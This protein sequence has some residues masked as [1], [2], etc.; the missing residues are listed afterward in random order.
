MKRSSIWRSTPCVLGSLLG[1]VL[2]KLNDFI[3]RQSWDRDDLYGDGIA[4]FVAR[5]DAN[6]GAELPLAI[7]LELASTGLMAAIASHPIEETST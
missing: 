2:A 3:G 5:W 7:S 4:A 6:S 1:P